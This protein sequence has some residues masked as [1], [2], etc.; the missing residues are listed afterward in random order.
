MTNLRV[1]FMGTPDFAVPTLEALQAAPDIDV[2]AVYS[3]PPRQAGRGKRLR[4]T[5]VHEAALT[6]GIAVFTPD[7]LKATE[8]Q[9]EFAGL[10]ADA[11]VVVAYGLILPGAVLRAPRL[12]CFNLHGSLLPRWRGAAP[13]QRAVMAGDATTGV[14]V[15]AMD[16]GLDTGDEISRAEVSIAADTTAGDLHDQLAVLGAPLMVTALR[17]VAAGDLTPQPQPDDGITYAKK[18]DKTEARI[19]WSLPNTVLDCRI[20]GLSPFP[21]A[22]CEWQGDRIKVLLSRPEAASHDAAPGTVLDENLLIA[23]GSGAVRLLR[24]QRSGK[25]V[26]AAADFLRGNPLQ[27]GDM[28]L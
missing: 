20:R 10:G 6:H 2:V 12:G 16:E 15:M 24:L 3:Q 26:M 14:C 5:A 11:A 25:G 9:A 19:D 8:A 17:G 21:G 28:L 27:T 22:W 18:I 1:V 23:C 4:H 7:S 13:I